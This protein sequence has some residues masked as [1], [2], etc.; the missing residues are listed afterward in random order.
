MIWAWIVS[1]V[2]GI[3][4]KF[5]GYLAAFFTV[6]AAIAKIYLTGKNEAKSEAQEKIIDNVV[7]RNETDNEVR[8]AG[9]DTA[10][11]ELFDKYSR[12]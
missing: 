1:K 6:L 3:S 10:R 12:D 4:L 7:I 2:S 9:G 11:N 8:N 5:W